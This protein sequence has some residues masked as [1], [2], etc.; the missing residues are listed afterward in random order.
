MMQTPT[1]SPPLREHVTYSEPPARNGAAIVS[2][3]CAILWPLI[4]F[5]IPVWNIATHFAPTPS[6]LGTLIGFSLAVLPLAGVI[7]ATIGLVRSF[8]LPQLVHSRW[9]AIVGLIF[10]VMWVGGYFLLG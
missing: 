4:V 3:I 7:L 2:L 10:G 8:S 6:W 5:S 9:Q 1:P